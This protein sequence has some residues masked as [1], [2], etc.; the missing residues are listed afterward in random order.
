M[1]PIFHSESR[2]L[3]MLQTQWK[4]QLDPLL[5]TPFMPSI[6]KNISLNSG[7]TVINHKLGKLPQGWF[8]VDIDGAVTIYRSKPFTSTTLTLN[9][10]AAVIVSIAVY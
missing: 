5:S 8:I 4:A 3:T 10:S 2:E 1:L 6:L 9:S 7:S